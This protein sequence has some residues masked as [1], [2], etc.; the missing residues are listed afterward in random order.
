MIQRRVISA[1]SKHLKSPVSVPRKPPTKR[2]HQQ[3]Q[4]K[5]FESQ[6]KI[7]SFDYIDS[8]LTPP[9][10]AFE[11]SDDHVVFY[12]LETNVL[13]VPEVTD[14]VRVDRDLHVKLFYKVSPL[15]L[16]QWFCHGSDCRFTRKSMMQNFPSYIKLEG[17]QTY[18][19]LEELKE[20]KFKKRKNILVQ[21]Y[22][23]FTSSTLYF[24]RNYRLLMKEFP[25]PALSLLK[26]ITE[27]QLDA[28]KFAKSLKPQ[29]V[30]SEDVVLMFDEMYLQ[31]CEEYF[32]GEIIGANENNEL[33]KGLLSFM[34]AGLKENVPYIIKSVPE[35]NIDG[36]WIKKEILDS[37]KTLKNCGFRVRAMVSDNHSANVLA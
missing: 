18:N 14:C 29:G 1:E 25:F 16:P 36:E 6:D 32:G 15:P 33:Y 19:I 37:L 26:K 4:F 34:I 10:Y 24:L 28:V 13:N 7:K 21:C 30:I 23:I 22:S 12:R 17:E 8:T 11:K 3:D 9:G 5:L 35:R 31:K 2:V 20:L 27:R